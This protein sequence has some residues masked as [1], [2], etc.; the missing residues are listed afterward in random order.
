[1]SV[2]KQWYVKRRCSYKNGLNLF[3]GIKF[4]TLAT[5]RIGNAIMTFNAKS[6]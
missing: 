6:Q 5:D 1:M 3:F 2:R 4:I